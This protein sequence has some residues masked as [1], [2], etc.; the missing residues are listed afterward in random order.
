MPTLLFF[1]SACLFHIG[2][3]YASFAS[4][5]LMSIVLMVS[6]FRPWPCAVVFFA[7]VWILLRVIVAQDLLEKRA[8]PPT[9]WKQNLP[10]HIVVL[11]QIQH[12]NRRSVIEA[13]VAVELN[14]ERRDFRVRLSQY[15]PV[16]EWVVGE[17]C[18][19]V[20]RL[21]P[22]HGYA[23]WG[24]R[25]SEQ[26][27]LASGIQ[28]HGYVY[29][30]QAETCH[31]ERL[32]LSRVERYR[33]SVLSYLQQIVADVEQRAILS[34]L[35]VGAHEQS[36]A[37]RDVFLRTGTSHLLAISGL[38][39]GLVV[40][41][42]HLLLHPVVRAA[43]VIFGL[44]T[45]H[46]MSLMLLA[47]LIL[48]YVHLT[49]NAFSSQRAAYMFL[50]G[51]A[52]QAALLPSQRL[53]VWLLC[54]FLMT[55]FNPWAV[56]D[57]GFCLSFSM[58]GVVLW[59]SQEKPLLRQHLK[60]SILAF[61]LSLCLLG[62]ASWVSLL[63]NLVA[64]P[65]VSFVMVPLLI[66]VDVT[67][68]LF[69]SLG[70]WAT[71]GATYAAA[72]LLKAL[73]FMSLPSM[74]FVPLASTLARACLMV[75]LCL[76]VVGWPA[77]T[78]YAG[79]YCLLL[80][81]QLSPPTP[82]RGEVWVTVLDVG[83]G[84]SVFIQTTHH[85]LLYDTG[86]KYDNFAIAEQTIIP[87]LQAQAI[88]KLDELWITHEDMDH[89][90]GLASVR[91]RYPE[92]AVY[93]GHPWGRKASVKSCHAR[94]DWGWDGVAFTPLPIPRALQDTEN[95]HSCVLKI[96]NSAGSVLLTGD[97]ERGVEN[98]LQQF[99]EKIQANVL[100]SPHHGSGTSSQASFLQ[101]VNPQTVLI[102]A[103]FLNPYHHPHPRVIS[104]YEKLGVRILNTAQLGGI[105]VKLTKKQGIVWECYRDTT[106]SK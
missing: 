90:G 53:T 34:A 5:V 4:I 68:V 62:Q 15:R 44:R 64:I 95:N 18:D 83:Q 50:L 20:V 33:Q 42:C 106:C 29:Q 79:W 61:T 81:L 6:F 76:L 69:P 105:R 102:S 41:L 47:P 66:V 97:I 12:T 48:G 21:R 37:L 71:V 59:M 63:S 93:A 32:W 55:Q 78:T 60:I 7:A 25:R 43:V 13:V 46:W 36:A 101:R 52:V 58:V 91:L 14:H 86:P 30:V 72:V 2:L 38:H 19:G 1:A 8:L 56:Y 65:W 17:G 40:V 11:K 104:R 57:L 3:L 28:L 73:T 35:A 24:G 74:V 70:K 80:A 87:F 67:H 85:T 22:A 23:N 88:S 92:A 99:P 75:G 82:A 39:V 27:S 98:Y 94:H 9:A 16:R 103:G 84:L 26:Q 89:K 45:G 77:I 10:A 96:S 51:Y 49:G 100:L 31:L 54:F